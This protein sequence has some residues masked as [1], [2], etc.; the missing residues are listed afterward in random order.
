[1][2]VI[3]DSKVL[4]DRIAPLFDEEFVTVDTEFMREKTYYPI[5]CLVQIAGTNDAFA[6]DPMAKDIN[7]EPFFKLMQDKNVLKVMHACEQD[8]EILLQLAGK[9]PKPMVDT[10]VAAQVLGYGE[11]MGY[12]NLVEKICRVSLDKSSRHT[13]WSKR[14][15]TPKQIEYAISD[16]THLR[17]VYQHIAA[18][19]KIKGRE[20]WLEEEMEY[21]RDV[22]RYDTDPEHAW[23]KLKVKSGKG[24]FLAV[25]KE[26]AKWRE[27]RAQKVDKPR[28]WVL[29]NDGIMEIASHMPERVEQL[30]GL[31]FY[32]NR[33]K[34][35]SEEIIR[36]VQKGLKSRPPE[37]EKK[38]PLPKNAGPLMDLMKV[39]LKAQSA[40]HEVAPSIVATA[41]DLEQIAI[42]RDPL[43]DKSIGCMHGWR[44]D[45]FGKYA[46]K[47]K[48]GEL[49]L[50][51]DRNRVQLIEPDYA[52]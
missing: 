29:K 4:K 14:P 50:T 38:Q 43:A 13:D 3:T 39:L 42:L 47:L 11:S 40:Q 25:V 45:V 37:F 24:P 15:L 27:I 8:M 51:V 17:K 10:Q 6:I 18:D 28:S 33:D 2:N 44:Y 20:T 19:L 5:L 9:L 12:G 52:A 31:R 48:R 22:K 1:M 36:V 49:A 35:L 7:L 16:V 34:S 21:Y 41:E 23:E 32:S 30:N 26:L 46:L